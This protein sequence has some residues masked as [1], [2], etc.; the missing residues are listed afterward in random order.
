MVDI[1]GGGGASGAAG[2]REVKAAIARKVKPGSRI[3]FIINMFPVKMKSA[4]I[5]IIKNPPDQSG[6][7]DCSWY[8]LQASIIS[9]SG[10]R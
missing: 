5:S 3:I 2:G 10:T 9:T 4:V 1:A 7:K 6:G 8:R